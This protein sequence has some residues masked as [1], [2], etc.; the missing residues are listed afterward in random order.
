MN[1]EKYFARPDTPATNSPIGRLMA[2]ILEK[3]SALSFD[4]AR[5]QAL[6]ALGHESPQQDAIGEFSFDRFHCQNCGMD[7]A[8]RKA[9]AE[10]CSD[11][12]SK[13]M[14]RKRRFRRGALKKS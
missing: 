12:C 8:G 9:T 14:R 1:L 6:A 13:A 4:E 7:L 2:R 11:A 10:F 3:N 5:I